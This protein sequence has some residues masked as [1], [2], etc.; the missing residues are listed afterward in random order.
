M[1]ISC[2]FLCNSQRNCF[3]FLLQ[4][5]LRQRDPESITQDVITEIVANQLG[6]VAPMNEEIMGKFKE[7]LSG[8][9][10]QQG[11]DVE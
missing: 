1:R 9:M 4:D 8:M 6:K 7:L 2:I 5:E 3:C 11:D 10:N